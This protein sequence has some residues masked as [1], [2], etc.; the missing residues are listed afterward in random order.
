MDIRHY[1]AQAEK[2]YSYRIKTVFP[3]TDDVMGRI[4]QLILKYKP[5]DLGS[6]RKTMF[7]KAPLDFP[8]VQGAEVYMLDIELG[9]PCS[10]VVLARE[11]T[12]ALG[13]PD[14]FIVVRGENDP[15]ELETERMVAKAEMDETAEKAGETPG[16]RLDLPGYDEVEAQDGSELYG[17][18]YNRRFLGH[19]KAVEDERIEAMK[20]KNTPAPFGWLDVKADP[21]V[22][23]DP[24]P[25]IGMEAGK[26]NDQIGNR[27]NL[28]N[29]RQKYTRLYQK[30]GKTY[31]KRS[32][33]D[34]VRKG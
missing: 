13:V 3:L 15:T 29:A 26:E 11:L 9:L 23:T 1:I 30:Q 34:P 17:D 16:A 27:G 5:L 32:D 31:V 21:E 25:T 14:K 22:P 33:G 19:L 12:Q 7:Q 8:T 24:G 20:L 10:G 28:D 2:T 4:E 6:P 18:K